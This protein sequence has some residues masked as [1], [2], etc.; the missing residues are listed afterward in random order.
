[1][2]ETN[3]KMNKMVSSKMRAMAIIPIVLFF[4]LISGDR[5][6]DLDIA[7]QLTINIEAIN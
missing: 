6:V 7:N 5:L 1:M 4:R 2:N 3:C